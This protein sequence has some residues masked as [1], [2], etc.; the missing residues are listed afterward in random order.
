MS[1]MSVYVFSLFSNRK[2]LIKCANNKRA[3]Y[4][5][6]L[7]FGP[8]LKR[9]FKV[10]WFMNPLDKCIRSVRALRLD[11]GACFRYL[12]L[13]LKFNGA[14]TVKM[15]VCRFEMR[16]NTRCPAVLRD[17]QSKQT[18]WVIRNTPQHTCELILV[19]RREL[20]CIVHT[21]GMCSVY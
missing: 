11:R 8:H 15:C 17:T 5:E 19:N 9:P 14:N 1:Q 13:F 2:S 4:F 18:H 20:P 16:V 3:Y 21:L 6:Q 12:D 10:R 7:V